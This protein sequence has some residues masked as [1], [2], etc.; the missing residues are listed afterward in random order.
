M[1]R[2]LTRFITALLFL[3]QQ[4]YAQP[5]FQWG[6]RGGSGWSDYSYRF[7]HVVD[8]ATDPHGN[9]YVLAE[10]ALGVVNV[11]GQLGISNY[12][13]YSLAS[14]DCEGNYRWKKTLGSAAGFLG[15]A[16][17][18]D[19]LGGVY[20]TGTQ[21]STN[22]VG[23]TYFDTDTLLG[24]TPKSMFLVKYDTSGVFQWLKMPQPDTVTAIT[25]ALSGAIDMSVSGAGDI[26]LFCVL[27]PGNYEHSQILISEEG[28]YV[29]KFNRFGAYQSHIRLD[30]STTD[31]GNPNNVGGT[32]NASTAHFVRDHRNNRFYLAG[33]YNNDFG[34]LS[35]GN[36]SIEAIGSSGM[37]RLYI[38]AFNSTGSSLWVKQADPTHGGDPYYR[39]AINQQGHIFMGGSVTIGNSFGGYNFTSLGQGSVP[40]V[41]AL[42]TNGNNIWATHG[43]SLN[44]GMSASAI[45]CSNNEVAV[46]G[47]YGRTFVWQQ[48]TMTAPV[49]PSG[50]T[51]PFIARFNATT[52]QL[53]KM[54]SIRSDSTLTNNPT[55]LTSDKN[56]NF[57]VGGRFMSRLYVGQNTLTKIGPGGSYDWFV[58]KFGTDN[59]DC[60]LPQPAFTQVNGSGNSVSFTYTGTTPYNTISWDFGDGSTPG[61]AANPTY[62]YSVAGTYTVCV[63]V[64]NDCGSNTS[65]QSIQA[66]G[67]SIV[68]IPGFAAI[69]LYP[70]PVT[71]RIYVENAGIGSVVDIF[72]TVGQRMLTTTIKGE[73]EVL[74]VSALSAGV[75]LIRFTDDK[76]RQVTSR[77][78]KH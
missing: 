29:I 67:S 74:D 36:T 63:T 1:I 49:I 52:G 48:D 33:A 77:F 18:T 61:T 30:M 55:A 31:G 43:H 70:N 5:S 37:P 71:Q 58:A 10:N 27:T 50:I 22:P 51:Y 45:A 16:I 64:T 35:F 7:E 69:K 4:L 38:T 2:N 59:C 42:D 57:Y 72:S 24:A 3:T 8:M 39:P 40:I 68:G 60:D 11:D 56:N 41:I 76:G 65:C 78:V 28:Y 46:A 75:Y 14:W 12:D 47:A 32:Y 44:V 17:G 25:S 15:F 19:T 73:Q 9:V 21:S 23:Y 62:T 53:I 34:T 54:D 26:F 13:R 66:G 20:L 6:K